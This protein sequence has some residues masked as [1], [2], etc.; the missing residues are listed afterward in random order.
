MPVASVPVGH[1]AL[2]V[3]SGEEVHA[4]VVGGSVIEGYPDSDYGGSFG[5]VEVGVVLVPGFFASDSWGFEQCHVLEHFDLAAEQVFE[6]F[7][8]FGVVHEGLGGGVEVAKPHEFAH[9]V[10]VAISTDFFDFASGFVFELQL[11]PFGVFVEDDVEHGAEY[12]VNFLLV[13]GVCYR[14]KP[15][16]MVLFDH[17]LV[18]RGEAVDRRYAHFGSVQVV[19][20]LF[21]WNVIKRDAHESG[22]G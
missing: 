9:V 7:H 1:G 5:Q 19:G 22:C 8:Q 12:R 14:H 21:D 20:V 15:E 16:L 18:E 11:D 4:A 3:P 17:C 10:E 2:L 6:D 13:D